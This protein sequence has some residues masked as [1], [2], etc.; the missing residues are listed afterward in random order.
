[1]TFAD[2]GPVASQDLL[3]VSAFLDGPADVAVYREAL[4]RI[5]RVALPA[6]QSQAFISH[7]ADE[8]GRAEAG[9]NAGD[10]MAAE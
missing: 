4:D 8:Y 3:N 7:L 2:H 10:G 1:M 9:H 5:G 6:G